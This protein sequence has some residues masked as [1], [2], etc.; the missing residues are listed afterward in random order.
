MSAVPPLLFA[1]ARRVVP[2]AVVAAGVVTSTVVV[3]LPGVASAASTYHVATNGSDSSAGTSARPFRT[4]QRAVNAAGPGS[5]ILVHRGTYGGSVTITKSG[6]ARAPITLQ[7]AGDG[8]V[9]L[10]DS[11]RARSCAEN[12][13]AV[14][15]TVKIKDGADFWTVK[16]F[17]INNGVWVSGDNANR[18]TSWFFDR[19]PWFMMGRK[20]GNWQERRAIPGQSKPDQAASR[21]AISYMNARMGLSGRAAMDPSEGVQLIGNTVT[22][23]GIHAT[24]A[25]DGKMLGN[26]VRN[27][28]C[29]TGPGIW[30]VALSSNWQVS[31]N[32]V[33]D[34][35]DT[36]V[37]H[38]QEGIRVSDAASYNTISGNRVHDMPTDG[39]GF[40]TDVDASF[41]TFQGN[42]ATNVYIGYSDEMSGRGNKYLGNTADRVRKYGFGLMSPDWNAARPSVDTSTQDVV[43]SCNRVTNSPS[44]QFIAGSS[45]G[46]RFDR[47]SFR[48]ALL[49]PNLQ[50]YWGSA[51][52]LWDGR[53]AS[54]GKSLA[55]SAARC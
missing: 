49:A 9:T 48:G 52:N 34:V 17:T 22:G 50:R 28:D 20:V 1:R 23:R 41:N 37:H 11:F 54:P 10:T 25:R 3:A 42:T 12:G 14:D 21:S 24:L 4:V 44:P 7:T 55:P 8:P 13:P 36:K 6:T 31:G 40:T 15:R 38:M 5:T 53:P 19:A 32:D 26:T 27:I 29:G 45:M 39:R 43:M 47:N 33:S 51:G 46:G 30:V 18:F 16:G 2:A 35:K